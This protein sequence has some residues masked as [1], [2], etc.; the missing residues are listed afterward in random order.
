MPEDL[1]DYSGHGT[2]VAS[3]A[4]GKQFGVASRANLHLLKATNSF[5]SRDENGELII[6]TPLFN[7]LS[8]SECFLNI[9]HDIVLN[10]KEGKAVINMSIG[11]SHLHSQEKEAV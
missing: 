7:D 9:L 11:K 4:A 3:I 6:D 8:L 10:N 1:T 2:M 5:L